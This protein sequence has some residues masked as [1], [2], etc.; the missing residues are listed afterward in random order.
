[1]NAVRKIDLSQSQVHTSAQEAVDE[2]PSI[3]FCA[4][5]TVLFRPVAVMPWDTGLVEDARLKRWQMHGVA[6]CVIFAL[7]VLFTT[8]KND[9]VPVKKEN[10]E[11][12]ARLVIEEKF[13]PPPVEKVVEPAV[14]PVVDPVVK[15][16]KPEVKKRV[17]K[18]PVPKKA[19]VIEP[20]PKAKPIEKAPSEAELRAKARDK[21]ANS[22]LLALSNELSSIRQQVSSVPVGNLKTGGEKSNTVK[23]NVL[24]AKTDNTLS[25]G[26][27]VSQQTASVGLAGREQAN[28]VVSQAAVEAVEST[29]SASSYGQ[30]RSA[31]EVRR[32]MD[33][34]K[35]AIYSV[36]NR[37]LRKN[38]ALEGSFGFRMTIE[39]SG[40]ISSV[41]IINSELAD[42]SL[43]K[44][45]LARIRII[46]FES[47]SAGVTEVN[48]SFDF[49]PY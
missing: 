6:I 11:Q 3:E 5:N 7:M 20:K 17:E 33:A 12:Y 41:T 43:E 45:L 30:G 4:A 38:P 49:L 8:S 9:V 25:G 36:Y 28:V 31:E 16:P 23:R 44:R 35:G 21:A 27:A 48:Y 46:Q 15:K 10:R 42:P 14:K 34:N 47:A 22:G 24:A 26:A 29:V 37:A 19:E 18:K 2:T 40:V 1:M 32:V 13:I 39:P